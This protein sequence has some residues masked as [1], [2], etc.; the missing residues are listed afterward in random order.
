MAFN[1]AYLHDLK[2][3][4][5]HTF[6]VVQKIYSDFFFYFFLIRILYVIFPP[7]LHIYCSCQPLTFCVIQDVSIVFIPF[8][9]K[10][11]SKNKEEKQRFL[12]CQIIYLYFRCAMRMTEYNHVPIV[13]KYRQEAKVFI[14]IIWIDRNELLHIS[15]DC[16]NL[17]WF[18]VAYALRYRGIRANTFVLNNEAILLRILLNFSSLGEM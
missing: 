18:Q 11:Q 1:V 17:T 13:D 10:N 3:H 5:W 8:H 6:H 7:I 12:C 9:H 14:D 15:K 2:L 4:C 16:R